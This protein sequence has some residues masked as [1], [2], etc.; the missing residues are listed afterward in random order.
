MGGDAQRQVLSSR[1]SVEWSR[2][3]RQ[4]LAGSP[5]A[6]CPGA[7]SLPRRQ[8]EWRPIGAVLLAGAEDSKWPPG[9]R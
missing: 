7:S 6:P 8:M 5:P 3:P 9:G 1:I 2:G 4:L